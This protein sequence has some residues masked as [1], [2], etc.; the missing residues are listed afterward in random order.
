MSWKDMTPW[1]RRIGRNFEFKTDCCG[2]NYVDKKNE[3]FW[4]ANLPW[5]FFP[6]NYTLHKEAAKAKVYCE[7]R[8]KTQYM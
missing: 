5:A 6:Q 8:E 1:F 7:R 2:I 4:G 3:D